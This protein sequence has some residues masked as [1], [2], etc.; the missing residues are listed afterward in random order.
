MIIRKAN[1]ADLPWCAEE[2]MKFLKFYFPE[3]EID[4]GHI[5]KKLMDMITN[6]VLLVAD[7]CGKLT[8]M[9]GGVVFPNMWYLEE[10][11]LT[12]LFWWV[13]EPCRFGRS[14]ALLLK[15]FIRYGKEEVGACRIVM[16][17]LSISPVNGD[18]LIKRGF[19]L[20]ESAFVMEV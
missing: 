7:D 17:L 1:I 12:E 20:K 19:E 5:Y 8:G 18:A 4:T 15:E 13:S 14:S 2:G 9:I 11:E 10:T 3:K 6:Q 16:S